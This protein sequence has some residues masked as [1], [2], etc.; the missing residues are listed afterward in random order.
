MTILLILLLI[1]ILSYI[2]ADYIGGF[3]PDKEFMN[4]NYFIKDCVRIFDIFRLITKYV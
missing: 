3:L 1:I 2:L 4:D